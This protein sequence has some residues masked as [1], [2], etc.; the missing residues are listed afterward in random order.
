MATESVLVQYQGE[1]YSLIEPP[2]ETSQ[3]VLAQKK[4]LLGEV[5]LEAL[6][7]DLS[8]AGKFIRVAYNGVAG[9][10]ELQIVVQEIGYD[11]SKLCDK[12]A[13]TVVKFSRASNSMVLDLQS[14]YEYLV[15]GLEEMAVDTLAGCS[16]LAGDMAIAA[17]GLGDAFQM[18][19][20]K[21]EGLLKRTMEK[22]GQEDEYRQENE[23]RKK[24]MAEAEEAREK[25]IKAEERAEILY[26]EAQKEEIA[27][28][29]LSAALAVLSVV[30]IPTAP[31]AVAGAVVTGKKAHEARMEK[32]RQLEAMK[33]HAE[34]RKKAFAEIYEFARKIQTY[35][36][37]VKMGIGGDTA[38]KALHR[39]VGAL[40]SLTVTMLRAAD[41]WKKMQVHCKAISDMKMDKSLE[42]ALDVGHK[43]GMVIW[44]TSGFKRRAM[45][46]FAQWVALQSVCTT[47]SQQ[48]KPIQEQLYRS[49]SENPT[50]EES[51]K[52]IRAIAGEFLREIEEAY[53]AVDNDQAAR[54]KAI[55]DLKEADKQER[56]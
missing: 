25:A 51:R 41:F 31:L 2:P 17:E 13:I 5:N 24:Q 46:F 19:E 12:A 54:D 7:G 35:D 8:R 30:M 10:T 55:K 37:R 43:K 45:A 32:I 9:N 21:I 48:I 11:I 20:E 23:T 29:G 4:E 52:N 47:Y 14:T 16:A 34:Q 18:E 3:L 27:K 15:D 40:K 56:R 39:A 33:E 38:I 50:Y 36:G 44:K 49:I 28:S 6:V 1:T 42:K 53:A 22:K 26:R